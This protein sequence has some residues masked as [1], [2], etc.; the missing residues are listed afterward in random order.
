MLDSHCH[1]ND[2][3]LYA[4]R[5]EIIVDARSLGV[6]LFLCVGWDVDSSRKALSIAH[7]FDDVYVAVGLHPENL[8][9]ASEAD[10]ALI[11]ELAQDKK[12]VAIGEIG[13]D[14]HWFK[15]SEGH[16]RQ[17]RFFIRQIELAN[18]LN[19]PVSVHAR[20]AAEDTYDILSQHPLKRSGVLHDYS[21]STEM[22]SAFASLGFY[23]GFDGPITYKNSVVPKA[24]VIA[25]PADRILSETDAPYLTPVPFRGTINEPKRIVEIVE[26][27]A[28]L[29]KT[30]V[31]TLEKQI[32]ENYDRLFHV[33][34]K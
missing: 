30:D 10:L 31:C 23:F 27:M 25:A 28:A 13:L 19:L 11:K 17:K 16:E 3:A 6:S 14:Y 2:E 4:R 34:Q 5:K 15:A 26:A 12:V 29:R 20:E 21:G 24:N 18:E 32:R 8:E 22:L 7:E 9:G 1:L 33:E